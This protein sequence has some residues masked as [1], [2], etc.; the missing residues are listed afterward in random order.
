[1]LWEGRGKASVE[2]FALTNPALLCDDPARPCRY[3]SCTFGY[4]PN[5][6]PNGVMFVLDG[7]MWI[8]S[9]GA[10]FAHADGSAKW[11]RLGAQIA[12]ANTDW[13]TDPYTG[14]DANGYPA[15]TGGMAAIRGCSDLTTT[16][17]SKIFCEA[18]F[19]TPPLLQ[20]TGRVG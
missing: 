19:V 15:T 3:S 20:R 2:G 12:P 16:S 10:L 1:L 9:N 17:V 5:N 7:P 8:H 11:R 18:V 13:R 6:Y 14:Y 4:N